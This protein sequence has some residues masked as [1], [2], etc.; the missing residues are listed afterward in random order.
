MIP[1]GLNNCQKHLNA[2]FN[3]NIFRSGAN[4]YSIW[5]GSTLFGTH[6]TV[7][8]TSYLA[9]FQYACFETKKKPEYIIS[10][11]KVQTQIR[12]CRMQQYFDCWC[13]PYCDVC[14]IYQ[15]PFWGLQ[16]N[17]ILEISFFAVY[18]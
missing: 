5:S 9:L 16:T 3:T 8:D 12:C 1:S 15:L 4:E 17:Q 13:L 7:Y 10:W 11:K 6:P 18:V 2:V 14:T